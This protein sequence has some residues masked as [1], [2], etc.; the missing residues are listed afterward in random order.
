[1]NP[2]YNEQRRLLW[3]SWLYKWPS[4]SKEIGTVK[5]QMWQ[6]GRWKLSISVTKQT[7]QVTT[8]LCYFA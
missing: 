2:D 6:N 5:V 1:M 7:L 4:L 8:I 3:P